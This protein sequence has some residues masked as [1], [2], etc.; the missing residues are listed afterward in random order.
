MYCVILFRS[1]TDVQRAAALLRRSGLSAE[2]LRLPTALARGSCAQGIRLRESYLAAAMERLEK[3]A[4]LLSRGQGSAGLCQ[5]SLCTGIAVLGRLQLV[6][7][8]DVLLEEL[9]VVVHRQL[10]RV[11]LSR[12]CIDGSLCLTDGSLECFVIDDEEQLSCSY[13]LTFFHA[14]AGDEAGHLRAYLHVLHTLDGGGIGGLHRRT[15]RLY[16]YDGIFIVAEIGHA[17]AL[18]ATTRGEQQ[19]CCCNH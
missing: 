19:G 11:A 17:A 4:V 8:D 15:L 3:S 10:G 14:N 13:R 12:S 16:R 2:P 5:L 9:L 7:S 6:L 18:A 1:L